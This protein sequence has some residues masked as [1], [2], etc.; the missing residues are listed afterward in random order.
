MTLLGARRVTRISKLA[1]MAIGVKA[2]VHPYETLPRL[3]A[4]ELIRR[5][6]RE[7]DVDPPEPGAR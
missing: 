1:P 5:Q 2:L 7:V 4:L 6:A 3:G